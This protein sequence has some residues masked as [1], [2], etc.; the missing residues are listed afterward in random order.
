MLAYSAFLWSSI[1]CLAQE[2]SWTWAF[3]EEKSLPKELSDFSELETESK[4]E[5][6]AQSKL[7]ISKLQGFGYLEASLDS[8]QQSEKGKVAHV[9]IGPQY[10]KMVLDLSG[11][12]QVA[13]NKSKSRFKSTSAEVSLSE[14]RALIDDL[15]AYYENN[16]HPFAFAYFEAQALTPE[17]F[18]AKLFLDKNYSVEVDSIDIIGNLNLSEGFLSK[19]IQIKEGDLYREE[20]IAAISQ[21]LNELPFLETI[22]PP[23]VKFHSNEARIK[24]YLKKRNASR[25]NFVLGFLP[26]SDTDGGVQVT[27]DGLIQL[28]NGLGWGEEILFEYKNF[29]QQLR[30]LKSQLRLPFIP[31]S[32]VGIDT[33]FDLVL[34]DTLHRNVNSSVA[35]SQRLKNN[36]EVR[37]FWERKGS[38]LL[39]VDSDAILERSQVP[40][41]L[42][43][44]TNYYGVGYSWNNLDYLFNPR[45]GSFG[46][47]NFSLGTR[48]IIKNNSIIE[49]LERGEDIFDP[50]ANVDERITQLKFNWLVQKFF[51]IKKRGVFLAQLNSAL[52]RNLGSSSTENEEQYF[53]NEQY[54]IGGNKILRGFDEESIFVDMY[55]LATLEFRYLLG[56]NSYYFLFADNNFS[57]DLATTLGDKRSYHYGFGTGVNFETKAGIFGISYALGGNR[58]VQNDVS[59]KAPPLFRNGKI[60]FGYVSYF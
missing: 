26:S 45:R 43:Y 4:E 19:H 21:R 25:F 53:E 49:L 11:I 32:P 28:V 47:A 60:H 41:N 16:G 6:D 55:H 15:L 17:G 33:G 3:G 46:Q 52:T 42:D 59:T 13:L 24:L 31:G 38:R 50:Y 51:P 56:E 35:I 8:I 12:E 29:P 20:N 48:R 14:S 2:T 58:T 23:Q 30:E 54:R 57:T 34:R 40:E 9:Y 18:K 22:R 37:F 27:G 39:S 10:E 5:F 7:L 36:R 44:T 1:S